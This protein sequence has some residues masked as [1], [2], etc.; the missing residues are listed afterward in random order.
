[1][2]VCL[3][4]HEDH[5]YQRQKGQNELERTEDHRLTSTAQ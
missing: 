5:D 1:M 4:Q 3:Q 2:S